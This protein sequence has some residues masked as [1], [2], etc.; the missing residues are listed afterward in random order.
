[1]QKE[2]ILKNFKDLEKAASLLAGSIKKYKPYNPKVQYT[3][4][5]MEYYDALSWSPTRCAT[6]F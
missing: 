4:R 1:M 5:Q 3:P 2:F 6:V